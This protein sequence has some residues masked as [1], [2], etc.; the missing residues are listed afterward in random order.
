MLPHGPMCQP[1]P[2]ERPGGARSTTS[3]ASNK[4][5]NGTPLSPEA[6]W[7]SQFHTVDTKPD[8]S[9]L[10]HVGPAQ[11]Q[12]HN[13]AKHNNLIDAPPYSRRASKYR[14]GRHSLNPCTE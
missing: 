9:K 5:P 1:S 11:A 6:R 14:Q 13:P 10:N 3:Q 8:T 4:P 2:A 7:L 12:K